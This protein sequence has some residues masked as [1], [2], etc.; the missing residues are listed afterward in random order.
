MKNLKTLMPFLKQHSFELLAGFLFMLLQNYSYMKTPAYIQKALD[1]ITGQN[2]FALI[3]ADLL[4]IVIY[5]VLTVVSMYLM[6]KLI[7]SVSR[8]IEYTLREKLYHKLLALDMG[9]FQKNETGDLVSR[10][11]N[12]LSNVRDLLGPGIMYIPNSLSR[13]VLFL[14]VLIS[15]SLPLMLI[16][17][18]LMVVLVIFIT[19]L[20]PR[21]RPM[22]QK[23]QESEGMINS[24]V[25]QVISGMTTIKLYTLEDTEIERFQTLT[26]EYVR[27]NMTIVMYRDVLWPLFIF[28][29]SLIELIV[30]LFGGKQVIQ[31]AMTIGQLLQFTVM[32]SQ[33]TFPVLSLGWM[34]S[35]IQQ[36]ISALVRMN[37]ILDYPVEQR[38]DWKTLDAEELTFSARNL[39]YHYPN[40]QGHALQQ[41]NL[42]IAPGQVVGITGTIGSGK[43]TLLNLMTGLFKPEPGMLFVNGM[44]IREIHPESL[45][46]KISIVSQE[47]FLFSR[48]IAENVALG[49]NGQVDPDTIK[50]AVRRAGLE[51]DVLTFPD[52]YDQIIGERGITLSGGQK[53]RTAIARALRKRSPVL[54]FDDALSSVDA[55]TEAEILD[56]LK[57]RDAFKTLIII[58]HRISALKN[59]DIIYVLDQGT[60]VEQGTHAELLQEGK[61]YARLANLQQMEMEIG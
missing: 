18:V 29:F 4:M 1:E 12:D 27:R 24:R 58:S 45:F 47:P 41:I 50:E 3:R 13:F 56:S 5:T 51:R 16:V 57:T 49:T 48:S 61:L 11:T 17:T 8:K 7:I 26:N 15:L 33:L 2:R 53:Q 38:D 43:T 23:I 9:F 22:Y 37:Y 20:M 36:G 39:S 35:M 44:D 42:T 6:R 59:A 19:V 10:C 54:V 34:M 28:L 21:L 40:Q 52:Q 14:P 30:L 32:V 46:A 25:W 60:L 55:K 31:H